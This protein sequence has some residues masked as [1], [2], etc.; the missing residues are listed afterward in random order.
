MLSGRC[1]AIS[2]VKTFFSQLIKMHLIQCTVIT[3]APNYIKDIWLIK[4]SENDVQEFFSTAICKLHEFN[5]AALH[6][7]ILSKASKQIISKNNK[8]TNKQK[9]AFSLVI[10]RVG[11]FSLMLLLEALSNTSLFQKQELQSLSSYCRFQG[12]HI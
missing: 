1:W 6:T 12:L 4:T 7:K 5:N 9:A 2:V 8:Q 3:K 10:F 11:A